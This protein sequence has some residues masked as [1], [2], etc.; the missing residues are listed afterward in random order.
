M[1]CGGVRPT[2]PPT[3][4]PGRASLLMTC[5]LGCWTLATVPTMMDSWRMWCA[6]ES[7]RCGGSTQRGGIGVQGCT[8]RE[9]GQVRHWLR[10]QAS[11]YFLFFPGTTLGSVPPWTLP[12]PPSPSHQQCL[13]VVN[14]SPSTCLQSHT[15]P[16]M[17]GR[18]KHGGPDPSRS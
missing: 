4:T 3:C 11:R 7:G 18:G 1:R 15:M 12:S 9:G 17:V 8:H 16:G 6:A 14:L 10:Q 2:S 5:A 13:A